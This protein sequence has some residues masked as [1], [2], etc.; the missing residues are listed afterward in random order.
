MCRTE[1]VATGLHLLSAHLAVALMVIRA[2]GLWLLYAI[3]NIHIQISTCWRHCVCLLHFGSGYSFSVWSITPDQ[4][5]ETQGQT[6]D[7]HRKPTQIPCIFS[8]PFILIVLAWHAIIPTSGQTVLPSSQ[9]MAFL[10][11]EKSLYCSTLGEMAREG[12]WRRGTSISI[13][14][15]RSQWGKQQIRTHWSNQQSALRLNNRPGQIKM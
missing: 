15:R 8:D 10:S 9:E 13:T 7:W 6:P 2:Y 4:F 3:E 12:A 11:P 14:S 1:T 5:Y